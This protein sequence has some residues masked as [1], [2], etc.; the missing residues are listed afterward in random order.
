MDPTRA[1]Q[2]ALTAATRR[3][4]HFAHASPL[5]FADSLA[6]L[7]VADDERRAIE[8]GI[9]NAMRRLYPELVLDDD[10]DRT[11]ANAFRTSIATEMQVTRARYSEDLL[12]RA[13][14]RGVR[15]YVIVGAGFDTFAYRRPDLRNQ[16]EVFEVD[17]PATQE[18]K[19]RRLEAAGI[20]HQPNLHFV[21]ADFEAENLADALGKSAYRSSDPAFFSWLGVI[22]YL[23]MDAILETMG[24][25]R[26]VVA[27]GSELVFDYVDSRYLDSENRPVEFQLH[28]DRIAAQG[29]PFQT[30]FTPESV[31]NLLQEQGLELLENLDPEQQQKRYFQGREDGLHARPYWHFVHCRIPSG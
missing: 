26:K 3:A 18:L 31:K 30:G 8:D 22:V 12:M 21:Q 2:T 29:E 17:H 13:I 14:E 19:R 1:S 24:A 10:R 16:I 27:P 25:I 15:Q 11:V 28:I 6:H 23:T 4:Y 20:S 9:I 7:L 5:V